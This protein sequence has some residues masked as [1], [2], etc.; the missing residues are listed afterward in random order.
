MNNEFRLTQFS[1]GAGCGCKI[2]PKELEIILKCDNSRMHF[3][4][5]LVGNE[6][7]DDAAV[8]DIGNGNAIVSTT[9]FFTPIVDNARNFGRIA[10]ANAISDVYAMGGFP[11]MA[12]AILGWPLDKLPAELAREVVDG[13]REVCASIK[14]PLAGGHS[15]NIDTPVFGLAVTGMIRS[16]RVKK[17]STATAGCRIFL[18][19]PLGIGIV[20]TAEK[21]GEVKLDDAAEALR[22]MTTLNVAGYDFAQLDG[23][24][25]MTDVTGFGL[26]GHALET[27]EGSNVQI[28]LEY[29]KLPR[30]KG[31]ENYINQDCIPGGTARN[32]NSYG[33][34]SIIDV[35]N[36]DKEKVKTLIC[37]PQTSGGLLVAVEPDAVA[38]LQKA[39]QK[40]DTPL[41]EIGYATEH[42]PGEAWVRVIA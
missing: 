29:N 27:A 42:K 36:E 12:I 22:L 3:A 20:T 40:T 35:I 41:F 8:Y 39:A 16:D 17:N 33:Q 11:L 30:L 31:V 13:A 34:K 28:I 23:V 24:R 25:A 7:C 18:T 2:A 4:D 32:W 37:D 15:I 6:N 26:L 21:H 1:P 5:L 9:D 10:A 14:I 38:D 19:K